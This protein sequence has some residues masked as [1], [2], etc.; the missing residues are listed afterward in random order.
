MSSISRRKWPAWTCLARPV[1]LDSD[2]NRRIRRDPL[3]KH[4]HLRVLVGLGLRISRRYEEASSAGADG[5]GLALFERS[6]FSQTP[7]APSNAAYRR[8]RATN[9]HLGQRVVVEQ[10][11]P[12]LG[13]LAQ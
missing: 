11:A 3:L 10:I 4:A 2:A 1:V 8:S 5:S 6:E 12:A 9:P 13:A 7:A